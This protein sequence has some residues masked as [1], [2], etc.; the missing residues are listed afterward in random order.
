MSGEEVH[1]KGAGNS[2]SSTPTL[3]NQ[4]FID[5][6]KKESAVSVGFLTWKGHRMEES[7][8]S[9]YNDKLHVSLINYVKEKMRG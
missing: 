8:I 5:L 3:T 1:P 9:W 4:V 2:R 6:E 7:E